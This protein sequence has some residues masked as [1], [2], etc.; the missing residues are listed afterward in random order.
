MLTVNKQLITNFDRR[1]SVSR[2]NRTR[3][4]RC[5]R[6]QQHSGM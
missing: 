1:T 3:T 2:C 6:W 4:S 5:C